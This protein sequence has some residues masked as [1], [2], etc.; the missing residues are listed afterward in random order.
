MADNNLKETRLVIGMDSDTYPSFVKQGDYLRAIDVDVSNTSQRGGGNF[1][2]TTW[3]NEQIATELPEGE[4][5][6]IGS[7]EDVTT[8]SVVY[9][10]A[11]SLGNHCIFRFYAETK[12]IVKLV[13]SSVLNFSPTFLIHSA[14]IINELC[15]WTDRY[16][17]P[18]KINLKKAE[19]GGYVDYNFDVLDLIKAPPMFPPLA[20]YGQDT[21]RII[22]YLAGKWFQFRTRYIF[23]DGEIS[24]LSPVSKLLFDGQYNP[25]ISPLNY[26]ELD[27]SDSALFA[28]RIDANNAS[29][30]V[31]TDIEICMRETDTQT[32]DWETNGS[33]EVW[34]SVE[35][36]SLVDMI[37]SPTPYKLRFYNDSSYPVI[38][39]AQSLKVYDSVPY[40]C[41]TLEF[42]QDRVFVADCEEGWFVIKGRRNGLDQNIS[43]TVNYGDYGEK[44]PYSGV[45][46]NGYEFSASDLTTFEGGGSVPNAT[47]EAGVGSE[48]FY[49]NLVFDTISDGSSVTISSGGNVTVDSGGNLFINYVFSYTIENYEEIIDDGVVSFIE[50]GFEIDK[51]GTDV[52]HREIITGN[53]TFTINLIIEASAGDFIRIRYFDTFQYEFSATSASYTVNFD[54]TAASLN[55]N[56]AS[57]V[58]TAGGYKRYGAYEFMLV[59]FDQ[60]GRIVATGYPER[61]YIKGEA[62][63]LDDTI[64]TLFKTGTAWI[65]WNITHLPPKEATHFQW[66]RTKDLNHN[67]YLEHVV[68]DVRYVKT[69]LE[70]S[71]GNLDLA[72]ME[73]PYTSADKKEIYISLR[74]VEFF[75]DSNTDSSIDAWIP[76]EGDRIRL[77]APS[78]TN[79][80]QTV[81]D[82][83]IK[84]MRGE[85]LVISLADATLILPEI[86]AGYLVEVYT[87]KLKSDVKIFYEFGEVYEIGNAGGENRFHK[88]NI[89]DQV[90]TEGTLVDLATTPALGIFSG[91]DTYY[92]KRNHITRGI[93]PGYPIDLGVEIVAPYYIESNQVSDFVRSSVNDI[94]RAFIYDANAKRKFYETKIRFSNPFN[95]EVTQ[96]GLSSFEALSESIL[97]TSFGRIRKLVAVA[98]EQLEGDIMLSICEKATV[99]LYIYEGF[100]QDSNQRLISISD[101]VIGKINKL[102]GEYGTMHP[103]SVAVFNE[104]AYWYDINA[105]AVMRYG[106]NGLIE[107]SKYLQE[108]FFFNLTKEILPYRDWIRVYGGIDPEK[109]LYVISFTP[110]ET[111]P[112]KLF[113]EEPDFLP[114]SENPYP[115][116]G[117]EGVE[118]PVVLPLPTAPEEIPMTVYSA[119]CPSEKP[120]IYPPPIDPVE[121]PE[122]PPLVVRA[123]MQMSNG[124]DAV[125]GFTSQF[126]VE[127]PLNR[128]DASVGD[129]IVVQYFAGVLSTG[130]SSTWYTDTLTVLFDG[131]NGLSAACSPTFSGLGLA[132]FLGVPQYG[133]LRNITR[134]TGYVEIGESSPPLGFPGET[135]IIGGSD[136]VEDP[137]VEVIFPSTYTYPTLTTAF[138]TENDRWIND[139]SFSL[140]NMARVG[141]QTFLSFKKGRLY[142]HNVVGS[143]T[144]HE[145]PF[146]PAVTYYFNNENPKQE[147]IW[148]GMRIDANK[149]WYVCDITNEKGQETHLKPNDFVNR[150]G[151]FYADILKDINTDDPTMLHP[152]LNGDDIRSVWIKVCVRPE[153]NENSELYFITAVSIESTGHK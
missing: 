142:I 59:Y 78:E 21:T 116:T 55:S 7:V 127:D 64:G 31:I 80:Y 29:R 114:N 46:T 79:Y 53:G 84:G 99:S 73:V 82:V 9:F 143:K 40:R 60:A 101:K 148:I 54:V 72:A 105:R 27:F 86:K 125:N 32:G 3:G 96:N 130:Q 66:T 100:I 145:I 135:V 132:F 118:Q 146:D 16:N 44:P 69:F 63:D 134:N 109:M 115:S 113:P 24:A 126:Y 92:R 106:R 87:P 140:E 37:N 8:L 62:E 85:Y 110:E 36:I 4:N 120:I 122:P 94:G 41:G 22:N 131:N 67:R 38:P 25:R 153:N 34:R 20:N 149:K 14:R 136:P 150:E 5:K 39:T 76:E 137:P 2:Q 45:Q 93:L 90:A 144:F 89:E 42:I 10:V 152:L 112:I 74:S 52:L 49:Q 65:T 61:V 88:G 98:K 129:I 47:D 58:A 70:D 91:G 151:K 19:E 35:V 124:N 50:C 1:I 119:C 43:L 123:K 68:Q 121:P 128:F 30:S 108:T 26:I 133:R 95:E 12:T 56:N 107:I 83:P 23:D 6:C 57:L 103:E 11:N 104:N 117:E 97:S 33:D 75:R 141:H 48:T 28:P 81:Y 71:D 15:Y 138:H 17:P 111:I 147:K 102:K 13:E 139:Y 77:L 18:R 51:N